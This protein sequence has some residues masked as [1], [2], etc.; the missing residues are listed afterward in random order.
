MKEMPL[1]FEH[2]Y[3][4]KI[5][6]VKMTN[7]IF[8]LPKYKISSENKICNLIIV[9]KGISRPKMKSYMFIVA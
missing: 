3:V 9:K 7:G 5:D 6:F 1:I 4:H 2:N 8:S